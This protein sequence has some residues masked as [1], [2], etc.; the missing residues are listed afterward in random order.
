MPKTGRFPKYLHLGID[1]DLDAKLRAEASRKGVSVAVLVRDILKQALAEGAAIEG[2]D[3]LDRAIR[4]AIKPD[5]DRLAK[6]LV[7]ST[8]AGAT[9]MY[10]NVQVLSDLGKHD[11]VNLYHLARKRAVEYLRLPEEGGGAE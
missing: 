1:N 10:L 8:M 11:A 7:K 4:R 9:A 2:R 6:L 3:A 5:V